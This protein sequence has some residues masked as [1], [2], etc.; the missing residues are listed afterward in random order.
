M[1]NGGDVHRIDASTITIRNITRTT[2]S[3][4]R[5]GDLGALVE[6]CGDLADEALHRRRRTIRMTP[7][8]G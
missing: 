4:N 3:R 1:E 6:S 8:A 2:V 7:N 5:A